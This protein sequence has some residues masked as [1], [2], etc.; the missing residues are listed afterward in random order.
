MHPIT[1]SGV[2]PPEAVGM[3][4]PL[5]ILT[6]T[7]ILFWQFTV[8]KTVSK[9][10]VSFINNWMTLK[11]GHPSL[12]YILSPMRDTVGTANHAVRMVIIIQ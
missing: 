2:G 7:A 8:M 11:I 4:I 6:A 10:L 12:K 3:V 1:V 9:S 5:N